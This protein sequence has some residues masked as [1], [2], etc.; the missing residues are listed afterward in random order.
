[1]LKIETQE[2]QAGP[3]R[4]YPI[5]KDGRKGAP[6]VPWTCDSRYS[7]W[8]CNISINRSLLEMQIPES[9]HRTIQSERTSTQYPSPPSAHRNLPSSG[10]GSSPATEPDRYLQGTVKECWSERVAICECSQ[11]GSLTAL[12][13]LQCPEHQLGWNRHVHR[14]DGTVPEPCLH[15]A[16]PRSLCDA[17]HRGFSVC[18]H[19]AGWGWLV[20]VCTANDQLLRH[21]Q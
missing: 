10:A 21:T 12:L 6:A 3:S 13:P 9:H 5:L 15:T 14:A 20:P 16:L 1:M 18:G 11:S 8:I 4:I 2:V 17:V 19:H 7:L